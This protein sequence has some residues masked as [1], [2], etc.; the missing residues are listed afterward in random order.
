MAG[1]G[2]GYGLAQVGKGMSEGLLKGTLLQGQMQTE[3]TRRN[4]A[5][6]L[7]QGKEAGLERR[8]YET[9]SETRRKN[10]EVEAQK[11]REEKIDKV[12]KA[13]QIAGK[14][15]DF[16]GSEDEANKAVQKLYEGSAPDEIIPKFTFK[17]GELKKVDVGGEIFLYDDNTL[18][19]LVKKVPLGSKAEALSYAIQNKIIKPIPKTPIPESEGAEQSRLS[20]ERHQKV[21]EAQGERRTKVLELKKDD[22]KALKVSDYATGIRTIASKYSV[23]AGLGITTD[24]AGNAKVD[25][26]SLAGGK[27]SFY[28]KLNSEIAKGNKEAKTDLEKLNKY[29]DAIDGILSKTTAEAPKGTALD[30]QEYANAKIAIEK[31]PERAKEIKELYKKNTGKEFLEPK[32]STGTPTVKPTRSTTPAPMTPPGLGQ[33]G[34]RVAVPSNVPGMGKIVG[35]KPEGPTQ[36]PDRKVIAAEFKHKGN[37]AGNYTIGGNKDQ[38]GYWDGTTFTWGRKAPSLKEITNQL[39]EEKAKTGS[40]TIEGYTGYWDGTTFTI[41]D[42]EE[43]EMSKTTETPKSSKPISQKVANPTKKYT[44]IHIGIGGKKEPK[45]YTREQIIKVLSDPEL[46]D[47]R[48]LL[49]NWGIDPEDFEEYLK[50]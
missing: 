46:K 27:K 12:L 50:N 5:L 16:G 6:A 24:A 26:A 4:Q 8:H 43:E 9:L 37:K 10:K 34:S 28:D 47:K 29:Y 38:V 19:D 41:G 11:A 7:A 23:D 17:K 35:T 30:D 22:E 25:L 14:I 45:E 42:I 32:G 44:V 39:R 49:K 3:Q 1:L 21:I 18:D 31:Y 40:Y 15:F 33:A 13:A 36:K 20:T 48:E 2:I